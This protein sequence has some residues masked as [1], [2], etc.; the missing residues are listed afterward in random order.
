MRSTGVKSLTHRD[1]H[2]HRFVGDFR[3]P[4]GAGPLLERSHHRELQ[5]V[6]FD[7]LSNGVLRVL[8]YRRTASFS[9]SIT[10]CW[11]AFTSL[12]SMKCPDSSTMFRTV[13]IVLIDADH[14]HI[15]LL[16]IDQQTAASC[17]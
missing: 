2:Q 5:S 12:S 17:S 14:G 9:V 11:R 7:D 6:Q 3:D 15:L 13:A 10:T 16:A 1:G 4:E 8:P